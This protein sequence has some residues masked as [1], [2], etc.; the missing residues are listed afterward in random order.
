MGVL[1]TGA[2]ISKNPATV[3][4]KG[5]QL[6]AANL[7]DAKDLPTGHVHVGVQAC[8]LCQCQA[9]QLLPVM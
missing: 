8:E 5:D 9:A 6:C 1:Q 4:L 7:S 3:L 2:E